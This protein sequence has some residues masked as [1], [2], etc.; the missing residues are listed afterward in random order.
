M[1]LRNCENQSLHFDQRR[2]HYIN[3]LLFIALQFYSYPRDK[4]ISTDADQR[5]M[6]QTF[7]HSQGPLH[8]KDASVVL[9]SLGSLQALWL[10]ASQLTSQSFSLQHWERTAVSTWRVKRDKVPQTWGTDLAQQE[11]LTK[12]NY[13]SICSVLGHPVLSAK[14]LLIL[15]ACTPFKI[16]KILFQSVPWPVSFSYAEVYTY[17]TDCG[18]ST[19]LLLDIL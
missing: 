8:Y 11:G 10:W 14:I 18:S 3:K 7:R 19:S 16:G 4:L 15:K 13:V 1:A 6:T 9:S 5:N 2:R 12:I 17:T